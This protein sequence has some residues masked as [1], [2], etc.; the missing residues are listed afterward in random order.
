MKRIGLAMLDGEEDLISKRIECSNHSTI[1]FFILF[2]T[3]R[4]A[5][6]G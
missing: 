1:Y 3:E 4:W 2:I 6:L 5:I